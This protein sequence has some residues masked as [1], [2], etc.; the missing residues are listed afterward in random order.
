MAVTLKEIL[1]ARDTLAGVINPTPILPD[2]KLTK[3]LGADVYLKAECLQ[4]GGS[5]KIRGAY[6]K[7]VGLSD[8][9]K[10]TGV[11]AASAGNHAQGVALAATLHDISSTIVLPE[12]APLTKV[13]ATKN[14]GGNVVL[15]G[16]SFDEAS[17]HARELRDEHGY[18][19]VHA[20]DDE[21]IIAGQGT[22][23]VEIAEGLPEVD[24]VIVPIGG[25]G[26]ISGIATAVKALRPKTRVIGVEA[27]NIAVINESLK[28][29]EP[30]EVPF[31]STIADGIAIKKPGGIPLEIIRE[32][33]D[34][35]VEVTEEEIAAGIFHCVQDSHL[36][37]EGAGAAG[38]AAVLSGKVRVSKGETICA[39]LCGGNIDANLLARILEHVLV[40]QGRYIILQ[41]LIVD[42]PGYLA[43]LIDKVAEKGGNVIEVFHQRSM[44]FAPLG[45]VGVELLLEVR[46][47]DHG[48]KL[49]SYLTDK[50]YQVKREGEGDWSK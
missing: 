30:V 14:F 32:T 4:R 28:A 12:Y 3:D 39:V 35:V 5:F 16:G 20:F 13:N 27:E 37:V 29:G 10:Q 48:Q 25:G 45:M 49:V 21:R 6:N 8:E 26:V 19:F 41:V 34:E 23:G 46:D 9:E 2:R 38:V 33:V 22:I 17:A 15:Y 24:K 40:R 42:R 11:V 7:I 36:V 1:E 47:E 50:G 31:A 44:W 43:A 18:T